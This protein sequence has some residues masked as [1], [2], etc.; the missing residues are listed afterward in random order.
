MVFDLTTGR[1]VAASDLFQKASLKELAAK[2]DRLR[3]AAVESA[4]QEGLKNLEGNQMTREDLS[5]L[6]EEPRQSLAR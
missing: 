4:F 6:L 3:A 5:E 1:R 2:V